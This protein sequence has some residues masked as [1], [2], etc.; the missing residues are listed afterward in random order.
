MAH[1]SPRKK[2]EVTKADIAKLKKKV[3]S[4]EKKIDKMQEEFA[5]I[6]EEPRKAIFEAFGMGGA[7]EVGAEYEKIRKKIEERKKH[8]SASEKKE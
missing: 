2:K 3:N 6:I 8:G 1:K 7:T 4:L 5:E